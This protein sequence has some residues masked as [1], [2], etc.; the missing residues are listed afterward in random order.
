MV[1]LAAGCSAAHS[2]MT[3]GTLYGVET[4]TTNYGDFE[5]T[6]KRRREP[7]TQTG[8]AVRTDSLQDQRG[9]ELAV[10]F[11]VRCEKFPKADRRFEPPLLQQRVSANRR[12][13]CIPGRS[14]SRN[15]RQC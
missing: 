8:P 10:R 9:F 13:A 7:K 4:L 15:G 12:S 5:R 6:P 1:E 3:Y 2:A 14:G 11:H